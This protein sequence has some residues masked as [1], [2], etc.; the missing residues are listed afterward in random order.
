MVQEIEVTAVIK[1]K[2]GV[3]TEI[4]YTTEM[5]AGYSTKTIRKWIRSDIYQN[6][7]FKEL[8]SLKI[9]EEA[10]IYDNE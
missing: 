2:L 7:N 9:R 6:Y 5:N 3:E 10:E 1:N 8:V 4:K